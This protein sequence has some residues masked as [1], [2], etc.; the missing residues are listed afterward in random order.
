MINAIR[1]GIDISLSRIDTAMTV[2]DAAIERAESCESVRAESGLDAMW[3]QEVK[4][5]SQLMTAACMLMKEP[6]E[7]L[8]DIKG[9]AY[10]LAENEKE[11]VKA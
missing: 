6:I 7:K 2:L 1:N 4:Y 10:Q 8:E 5:I 3:Q 11:S 9:A